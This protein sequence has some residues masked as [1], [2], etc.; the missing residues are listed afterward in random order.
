MDDEI[1]VPTGS[2]SRQDVADLV[3][4]V[5]LEIVAS[6][7]S[8]P[9]DADRALEEIASRLLDFA[10]EVRDDHSLKPLIL[11]TVTNLIQ[12]EEGAG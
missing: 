11:A 4:L 1:E 8:T 3:Y 2:P 6:L 12:T 10:N 7:S 9:A 5:T